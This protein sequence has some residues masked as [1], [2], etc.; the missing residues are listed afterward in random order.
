[1]GYYSDVV[2]GVNKKDLPKII[3]Q[4]KKA[5]SDGKVLDFVRAGLK[6][7]GEFGYE[8]NGGPLVIMRWISV[9]WYSYFA[10]TAFI[11]KV[12]M[13]EGGFD[14]AFIRIGEDYDDITV[15]YSER[16]YDNEISE[17]FD[18]VVQI[19]RE[20]VVSDSQAIRSGERLIE[21]LDCSKMT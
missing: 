6:D 10:E 15:S 11:E 18:N 12:I 9:K 2:L 13:Q 19:C 17:I 16:W 7:G 1:M 14:F 4:I 8:A 3:E 5:D 21:E 20:V